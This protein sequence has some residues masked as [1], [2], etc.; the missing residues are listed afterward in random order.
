MWINLSYNA[1]YIRCTFYTRFIVDYLF[2]LT[3]Y[4]SH[5]KRHKCFPVVKYK[6]KF[7]I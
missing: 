2:Q 1:Y 5:F 7:K 6:D 4:V 3:K